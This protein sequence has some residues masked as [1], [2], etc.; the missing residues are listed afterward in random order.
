[1]FGLHRKQRFEREVAE[2]MAYM[3]GLHGDPKA[4]A[5]GAAERARRPNISS[6]RAKVLQTASD[7]LRAQ[8]GR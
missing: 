6:S 2:E 7:R 5:E 8:V 4:A 1:M 3:L